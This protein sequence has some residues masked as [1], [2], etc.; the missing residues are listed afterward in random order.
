MRRS[1][2][3]NPC[4]HSVSD[5]LAFEAVQVTLRIARPV[6]T[7][8]LPSAPQNKPAA[9][10]TMQKGQRTVCLWITQELLLHKRVLAVLSL[11]RSGERERTCDGGDRSSDLLDDPVRA[12]FGGDGEH[13][14][15]EEALGWQSVSCDARRRREERTPLISGWKGAETGTSVSVGEPYFLR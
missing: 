11:V 12:S 4:H 1:S 7:R 3:V 13:R 14:A 9:H 5:Y 6:A 2:S 15:E 10:I 8:S